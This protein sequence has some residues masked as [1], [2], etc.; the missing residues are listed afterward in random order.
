MT[1]A[2]EGP[3]LFVG[4]G[5]MGT[6]M[7]TA[8]ARSGRELLLRDVDEA[9]A[10][11]LADQLGAT[12]VGA[13]A[14]APVVVLMLPDSAAVEGVLLGEQGLLTRLAAGAVVVDMS[15]SRPSSTVALAARA[16]EAGI[17]Y[18]DA[19]VSGGV[20]RARDASLAVMVGATDAAYARVQPLLAA[21]GGDVTHVGGPGAGHAMK[22]LNN[23]LSAIGLAAASEVLA[24]GANFGLEPQVMLDV[25]NR[26]TGRNHATEV[27]MARF[28]LS[29]AFDSGFSLRLMVKDLRT[30]LE[31]AHETG[32]PV[33]LSA[34]ALEE[35]TAAGRTLPADADHTHVAAY[36]ESRAGTELH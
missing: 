17:D 10:R 1:V 24:V 21:M 19:P 35:W 2:A 6:P 25:L 4:L 29:R 33:P 36:V 14:T 5:A 3:V 12:A 23:L 27:K 7:A 32:T 15:S 30:A 13:D 26:S 16:G 18:V 34:G 31:L 28:V 9:R 22:A 11:A 8:L 20:A